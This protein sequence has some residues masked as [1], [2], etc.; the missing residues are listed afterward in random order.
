MRINR[1][2]ILGTI[3]CIVT[4]SL[5]A[6]SIRGMVNDG[7]K[8]NL[9]EGIK[10]PRTIPNPNLGKQSH[11]ESNNKPDHESLRKEYLGTDKMILMNEYEVN[12]AL[13]NIDSKQLLKVEFGTPVKTISEGGK[14]RLTPVKD[15]E[16]KLDEISQ[17]H[18]LQGLKITHTIGGLNLSG[19]KKKK[20]SK[21]SKDILENVFNMKVEEE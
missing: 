7:R 3:F 15:Y 13:L 18:R 2:Y 16:Y 9:L 6:Q 1:R 20:L 11:V 17:K 8:R 14:M 19:F 21:K 5:Q 4:I 12:P 10:P